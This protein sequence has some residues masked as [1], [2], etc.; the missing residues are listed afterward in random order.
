[1]SDTRTE[2]YLRDAPLDDKGLD[3][4]SDPLYKCFFIERCGGFII[5]GKCESWCYVNVWLRVNSA[6]Y[7]SLSDLYQALRETLGYPVDGGGGVKKK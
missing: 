7:S 3:F 2:F 5:C 1:M 6:F 4:K